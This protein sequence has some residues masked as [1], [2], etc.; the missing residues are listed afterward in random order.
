MF[1]RPDRSNPSTYRNSVPFISEK[2]DKFCS[3]FFKNRR[4]RILE[5]FQLPMLE[6][7]KIKFSLSHLR[8]KMNK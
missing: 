8:E 7:K 1:T 6:I 5:I 4:T 2:I 3:N